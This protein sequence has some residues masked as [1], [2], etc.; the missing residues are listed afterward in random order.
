MQDWIM[1][2]LLHYS[3]ETEPHLRKQEVTERGFMQGSYVM[4]CALYKDFSHVQQT[5]KEQDQRQLR[6]KI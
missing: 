2:G 3:K 4:R 6:E 1:K 5:S